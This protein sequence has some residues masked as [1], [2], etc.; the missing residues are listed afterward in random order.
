MPP[1]FKAKYDDIID[2]L[3]RN[4]RVILAFLP[5][6]SEVAEEDELRKFLEEEEQALTVEKV[7]AEADA[8]HA[9]ELV[10]VGE[11]EE[12]H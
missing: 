1:S 5:T 12:L 10:R 8:F 6:P 2:A 7:F 9:A 11:K 3:Q 4:I